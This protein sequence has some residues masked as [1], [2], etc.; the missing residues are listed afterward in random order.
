ML[1]TYDCC[2]SAKYARSSSIITTEIRCA[3]IRSENLLTPTI[4][5]TDVTA[6][7][8]GA[9]LGCIIVALLIAMCGGALFHLLRS[10]TSGVVPKR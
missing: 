2:V 3:S 8:V 1:P 9:V 7:V 4:S 10:R 5:N 6:T